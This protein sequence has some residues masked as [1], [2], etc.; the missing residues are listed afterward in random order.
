MK[1][2]IHYSTN[3]FHYTIT[4]LGI[5]A[6]ILVFAGCNKNIPNE[7]LTIDITK[8]YPKKEIAFQDIANV[9][10]IPLEKNNEHPFHGNIS[11]FKNDKIIA[12]NY[13]GG[14]IFIF[15]KNGKIENIINHLG[16]GPEEYNAINGII[17][18][19]S[20]NELFVNNNRKNKILVYD[21][22]GEFK[23]SL[24]YLEDR[25]YQSICLFDGELIVCDDL[26]KN[27]S[28]TFFTISKTDGSMQKEIGPYF[29]NRIPP[30]TSED[31][32]NN[33][34]LSMIINYR[35]TA[36]SF[37]NN[38]ILNDISSD[39]IF[40]YTK[41]NSLQPRII[42]TPSVQNSTPAE[43]LIAEFETK[44][45]LFMRRIVK[46]FIYDKNDLSAGI[47]G[48]GN[49]L[50]YDKTNNEIYEP[51]FFNNQI[52]T[53]QETGIGSAF[54]GFFVN[55]YDAFNLIDYYE[56]RELE[57]ELAEIASKLDINDNPVLMV[58]D[59]N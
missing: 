51:Y 49:N 46:E 21:L 39:T 32:G 41:K 24:N 19:E 44:Q 4:T 31:L 2:K 12:Y 18:D 22:Q 58:V 47:S 27:E 6:L 29:S 52:L 33:T 54:N 50:L 53:E 36:F 59:Y 13:S 38:L 15:S 20:A 10:Y 1:K 11:D 35:K 42:Q 16:D 25:K 57:A 3:K 45:I 40:Q 23:R 48:R 37:D 9:S 30:T 34:I 14:D 17:Y 28:S 7:V 43:I 8:D 5:L 56:N 55:K 26:E